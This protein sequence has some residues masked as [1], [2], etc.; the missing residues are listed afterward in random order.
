MRG[1]CPRGNGKCKDFAATPVVAC[2]QMGDASKTRNATTKARI[3][4]AVYLES[5]GGMPDPQVAPS[6]GMS[7]NS[8]LTTID[9]RGLNNYQY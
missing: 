9:Y 6:S 4:R 8:L 1:V 2:V 3:S 5:L 7:T